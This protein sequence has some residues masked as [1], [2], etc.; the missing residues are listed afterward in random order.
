MGL[1]GLTIDGAVLISRVVAVA[2][3]TI[4]GAVLI[5]ID[6][7]GLTRTCAVL[8]SRVVPAPSS[9]LGVGSGPSLTTRCRLSC[10]DG[11]TPSSVLHEGPRP[12]ASVTRRATTFTRILTHLGSD[13]SSRRSVGAATSARIQFAGIRA[14]GKQPP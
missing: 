12:H 7:A 5:S 9:K 8:I 10:V 6:G 4:D 14:A 3:I 2:G 11:G 13:A 1:A